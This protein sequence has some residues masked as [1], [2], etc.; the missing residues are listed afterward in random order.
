[1]KVVLYTPPG[2]KTYTVHL[3]AQQEEKMRTLISE[4]SSEKGVYYFD[5][6][7]SPEFVDEDFFDPD[8]MSKR[9]AE[10]LTLKLYDFYKSRQ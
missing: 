6:L 4:V 9:G 2:H 10:K 1:M 8:H 5:L 7:R 3:N